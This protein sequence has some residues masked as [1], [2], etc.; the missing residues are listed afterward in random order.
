LPRAHSLLSEN[1]DG[2]HTRDAHQTY[3]DLLHTAFA[4]ACQSVAGGNCG[5]R[6][7]VAAVE[8]KIPVVFVGR[9]R[10]KA[11]GAGDRSMNRSGRRGKTVRKTSRLN[12]LKPSTG[13][14]LGGRHL[15]DAVEQNLSLVEAVA[16]QALAYGSR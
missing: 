11:R 1:A 6:D 14:K 15:S 10:E 2:W 5:G 8:K 16:D 12:G 3:D 7:I 13:E 9:W 4:R